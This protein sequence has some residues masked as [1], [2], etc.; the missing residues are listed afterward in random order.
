M[1]ILLLRNDKLLV[2]A[3]LPVAAGEHETDEDEDEDGG[4]GDADADAG[5]VGDAAA[6]EAVAVC[7]VGVVSL[8]EGV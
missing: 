8:V 3:S 5:G 4:G 7:R 2:E 6:F 1:L